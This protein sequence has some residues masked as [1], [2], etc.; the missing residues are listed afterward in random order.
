MRKFTDKEIENIAVEEFG[1]QLCGEDCY[2]FK[3]GFKKAVKLLKKENESIE[4]LSSPGAIEIKKIDIRKQD[5]MQKVAK[6][7]PKYPKEMLR[8]FYDYWTEHGEKDK[9]FRKEK[10]KSFDISKR[11][12]R[13]HKNYTPSKNSTTLNRQ[14][15]QTVRKNLEEVGENFINKLRKK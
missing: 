6:F 13:W 10:E 11:L 9:K 8:E 15:E 14:T 2:Y 12:A 1:L 5:F 4:M 7:I 3:E